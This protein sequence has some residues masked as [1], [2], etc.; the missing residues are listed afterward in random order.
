MPAHVGRHVWA[1]I[2]LHMRARAS[3]T[4]KHVLAI[5][6]SMCFLHV[7]ACYLFVRARLLFKNVRPGII[8]SIS[9]QFP[10]R[11][12]GSSRLLLSEFRDCGRIRFSFSMQNTQYLLLFGN[13]TVYMWRKQDNWWIFQIDEISCLPLFSDFESSWILRSV[14]IFPLKPIFGRIHVA[15]SGSDKKLTVYW[16]Q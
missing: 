10:L 8:E 6:A 12:P 7:R 14:L 4:C 13:H 3:Y 5:R 11:P 1:P 15:S 2:I 9:Q 16:V